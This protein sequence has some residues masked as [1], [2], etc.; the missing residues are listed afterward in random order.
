MTVLNQADDIWLGTTHVDA[1]YAGDTQVWPPSLNRSTLDFM[2][3]TGLNPYY[4]PI[5][6]GLVVGLKQSGLW[7]KMVAVYPFIGGTAELHKWNLLD[8]RDDDTAYRLTF[9]DGGTMAHSDVLGYLANTDGN[10]IDGGYADTH[11]IPS[12]V[13]ADVNSTHLAYHS[14][15]EVTPADRCEMGNYLWNGS[16]GAR[17]HIIACYVGNWF[18][19]GLGEEGATNCPSSTSVGLF[20]TTR[21]DAALTTAYR[22]GVKLD[23]STNPPTNGLPTQSIWVGGIDAY[24]GRS[25]LPCGFASIGS[26]LTPENV[27]DL[28]TI[29]QQYQ[30]AVR[31]VPPIPLPMTIA[32]LTIWLDA[33]Q[34]PALGGAAVSPWHDLSGNRQNGIVA[35]GP[36]P[37]LRANALNGLPVV[38]LTYGQGV[39]RWNATGVTNDFTIVY[40]ARIWDTS[41]DGTGAERERSHRP[42]LSTVG[43]AGIRT[44]VMPTGTST[45]TSHPRPPTG[46]CTP[47][48]R[49]QSRAS[50]GCIGTAPLSVEMLSSTA[51]SRAP[52]PYQATTPVATRIRPPTAR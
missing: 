5:L 42:T 20:V 4:A 36:P 7:S 44:W 33:S 13:L 51:T 47:R 32:G 25:D 28:N 37:T 12:D 15:A 29:V 2:A 6:D 50:P 16:T 23:S 27:A 34:I 35:N 52:W 8:P 21:T 40:M 9:Y 41:A 38:H 43:S 19:Y 46:S 39:F 1:I 49:T 17:F 11:L 26:G 24:R 10:Y 14:L 18:Y 48:P 3:A 22:D 30:T 45:A 31:I